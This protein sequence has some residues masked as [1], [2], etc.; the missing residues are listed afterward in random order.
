V[1]GSGGRRFD[2]VLF[3]WDDTLCFAEPHRYGHAQEVARAFGHDLSLAE[4]YAAFLRSGDSAP[5]TWRQFVGRLPEDLGI[6][7]DERA[8]FVHAYAQ[9]DAYKRF[10][11]YDDVLDLIEHIGRRELRVGLIS[12][13]DEVAEYV[14]LLDVTHRFEVIVSPVTDGIAKPHPEIFR[15]TLEAMGVPAARTIYVGDSYDNDVLGA[16]AAGLTPV[17]IDRF[18]LHHDR[19]DT[20]HRVAALSDLAELLDRLLGE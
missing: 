7:P 15:L 20:E 4:V 5:L 8:S 13:N 3:D 9:R 16:R 10:Q 17:L 1:N 2:A 6:H 19:L 18:A 14:Q 12:N 11:L